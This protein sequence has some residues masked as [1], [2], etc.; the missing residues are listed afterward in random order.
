MTVITGK[1][2][3]EPRTSNVIRFPRA[4]IPKPAAQVPYM[5][6]AALPDRSTREIPQ[7]NF[8]GRIHA[9]HRALSELINTIADA[10]A[11]I[12]RLENEIRIRKAVGENTAQL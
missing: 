2:Q 6:Y 12:M 5:N 3:G 10:R 7:E 8:Y 11:M 4:F 1:D 9:D